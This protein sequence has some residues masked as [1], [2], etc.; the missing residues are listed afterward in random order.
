MKEFHREDFANRTGLAQAWT[1]KS[2]DRLFTKT[3]KKKTI[4]NTRQLDSR[5]GLLQKLKN[6]KNPS[7]FDTTCTFPQ[8]D[9][10]GHVVRDYTRGHFIRPCPPSKIQP[11]KA[12][13]KQRPIPA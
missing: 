1:V 3:R 9:C 4:F 7:V 12:A 5:R 2:A 13:P 10:T 11:P 8:R 6:R